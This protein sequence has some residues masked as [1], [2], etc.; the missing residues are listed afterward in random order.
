MNIEQALAI[1][2]MAQLMHSHSF[3]LGDN[4]ETGQRTASQETHGGRVDFF[5]ALA[6]ISIIFT[7]INLYHDY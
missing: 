2:H 1:R 6:L 4:I 5:F 3:V 7:N